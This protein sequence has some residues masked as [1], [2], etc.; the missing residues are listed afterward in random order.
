MHLIER[1]ILKKYLN[2]LYEVILK[3]MRGNLTFVNNKY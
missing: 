2:L 1:L 3:Y